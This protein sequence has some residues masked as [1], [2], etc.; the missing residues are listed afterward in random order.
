MAPSNV[1]YTRI[2][3]C[4]CKFITVHHYLL[5]IFSQRL[6]VDEYP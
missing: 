2:A 5:R 4:L 1:R 6:I 3:F